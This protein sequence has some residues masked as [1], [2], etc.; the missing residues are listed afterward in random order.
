MPAGVILEY[1]GPKDIPQV[2]GNRAEVG[3]NHDSRK[4]VCA[5]LSVFK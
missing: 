5:T 2:P 3:Q 1:P 4:A